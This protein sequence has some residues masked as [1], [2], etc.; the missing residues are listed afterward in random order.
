[1]LCERLA[2]S[3]RWEWRPSL[4]PAYLEN[5]RVLDIYL[6]VAGGDV[7]KLGSKTRARS[8]V[9]ADDRMPAVTQSVASGQA[10]ELVGLLAFKP[11][12][13]QYEQAAY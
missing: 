2:A 11:L 12:H 1:M 3:S 5:G 6:H 10:V 9:P 4:A 13:K 7:I 8:G